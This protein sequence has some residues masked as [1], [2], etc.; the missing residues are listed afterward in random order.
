MHSLVRQRIERREAI[1]DYEAS[2]YHQDWQKQRRYH[3]TC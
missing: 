1:W 3:A 2:D